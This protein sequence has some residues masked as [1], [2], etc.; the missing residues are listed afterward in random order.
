[1]P[2]P[3]DSLSVRLL[4]VED[5]VVYLQLLGAVEAGSG[6]D[7]EGHSHPYSLSEPFDIE[8][9]RDREIARWSTPIDTPGWRRAWGLFDRHDLVGHLHLGGGEL[10]S[11][12]H[13]AELGMGIARTH[14]RRGGGGRLLRVAIAWA[15]S[16]PSIDWIDLG[17]FSDNPG[18]H[19]LYVR[20]GFQV[21]GRTTDR[22][23]IDG[24]SVDD[25]SMTLN[26]AD[27]DAD[28]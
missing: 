7:G 13:R 20:H 27:A 8:A 12:L 19:A 21:I 22:Y 6:V 15:R 3:E 28:A 4:D 14:R 11:E 1:M 9:G 2:T 18:A 26:V 24:L 23:R 10:R 25:S 16:Q 17:V 5:V